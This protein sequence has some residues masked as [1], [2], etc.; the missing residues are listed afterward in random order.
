[1]SLLKEISSYV[2]KLPS[3]LQQEVLHYAQ[4]L[5]FRMGKDGVK[6]RLNL[7]LSPDERRKRIL[8][9]FKQLHELGAFADI[10]D[11]VAWQ[12]EI[13]Q[14]RPLPGREG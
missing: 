2:S 8:D 6:N 5:E 12:R 9:G 4:F 11:P 3:E 1:M 14:D 7:D 10:E 13:R